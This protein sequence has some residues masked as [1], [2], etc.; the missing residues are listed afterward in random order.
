METQELITKISKEL[1]RMR[2]RQGL[3][4][5]KA[6]K[7]INRSRTTIYYYEAGVIT[8]LEKLNHYT[9][10]CYNTSIVEVIKKIMHLSS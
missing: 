10:Q 1:L 4:Q 9:S 5:G 6:A 8:D 2:E 3:T 7:I